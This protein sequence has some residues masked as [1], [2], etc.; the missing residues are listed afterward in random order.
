MD[1][2]HI[3]IFTGNYGSGKTE[4]AINYAQWLSKR[5]SRVLLVDLD[6]INPY[7]R[8]REKVK[9]LEEQ[10]IEVIYPKNLA[11]ADLPIITADVKKVMHNKDVYGIIDV[12]GD[13]EGAIALGSSFRELEG[14]KYEMNLVV[15]TMRPFTSNVDGIILA[16][17]RI[18]KR[19]QLEFSGIIC[20][21]NLGRETEL[22]HIEEGYPVVK[23]AASK[24][25]LPIKFIAIWEELLPLSNDLKIEEEIF[26]VK[27]YNNPP[28]I[29]K[30]G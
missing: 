28:W 25:G 8:S 4:L 5:V 9:M 19:S 16:K 20:N 7:F 30:K 2:N 14:Q 18:E 27:L 12:G 15:N 11:Q 13:E 26:P 17:E 21:I 6:V 3:T 23:E 1:F 22:K 10:D 24:M 29:N